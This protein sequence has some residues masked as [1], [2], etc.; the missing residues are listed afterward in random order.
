[1][2]VEISIFYKLFE[3]WFCV[4]V[5]AEPKAELFS[6]RNPYRLTQKSFGFW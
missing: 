5:G 3:D 6:H 2:H 4:V 1:M